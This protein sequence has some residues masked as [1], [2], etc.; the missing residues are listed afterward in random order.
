M[1]EFVKVTAENELL[2]SDLLSK[3][4][5]L[6]STRATV[7]TL[8]AVNKVL[9]AEKASLKKE[10]GRLEKEVDEWTA[11]ATGRLKEGY[12]ALAEKIG[13]VRTEFDLSP[14]GLHL[15]VHDGHLV[16]IPDD[17]EVDENPGVEVEDQRDASVN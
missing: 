16:E 3:T 1:T 9:S 7:A 17:K 15:R 13:D 5:D 2:R 8:D 14:Y 6:K 4:K 10:V 11:F 12:D